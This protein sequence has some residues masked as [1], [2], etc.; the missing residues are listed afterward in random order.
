MCVRL[1][2]AF[3]TTSTVE[4]ENSPWPTRK[5]FDL[6]EQQLVDHTVLA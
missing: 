2:W 3:S 4:G 6:S 5:L 1:C